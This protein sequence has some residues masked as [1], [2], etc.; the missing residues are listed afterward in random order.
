MPEPLTV[1]TVLSW[2]LTHLRQCVDIMLDTAKAIDSEASGAGA[3]VEQ[4]ES[5]FESAAGTASRQR[6]ADDKF[7]ATAT[8]DV[9]E[10]L[11]NSLALYVGELETNIAT[12]REQK[13]EAEDS[14]WDLFVAD[15]GHVKSRKSNWE[16]YSDY[17]PLGEA[18]IAAKEFWTRRYDNLISAALT[19][20]Q[21]VDQEGAELYIRH[22]EDLS[23]RVKKAVTAAP[24]DPELARILREYQTGSSTEPPRLWPVGLIADLLEESGI[25]V[26]PSL[27]TSEE[28]AAMEQLYKTRGIE[29]VGQALQMPDMA[30][31]AALT[32]SPETEADGHGDAFRHMYWNALM[33]QEFGAD[34]TETYATAHEKTGGNNPQREA[35]DLWNNQLGREIGAANP[36]A[37][38]E[39][40][41][42]LIRHE[43]EG[44]N[45]RALVITANDQAGNS[46]PSDQVNL[47][48]SRSTDPT[49]TGPPA[50][51]GIPLPGSK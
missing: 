16:T 44:E 4:S 40:L 34:W 32:Y 27:F 3:K 50:G 26:S 24:A 1:S 21:R 14:V 2:D 25:E 51:V 48:W 35:M 29:A 18:A 19:W 45:G 15:D 22:I 49:L 38:P 5:Y 6:G 30:K 47:S 12:I 36:N 20:V 13:K 37:T 43:I 17:F 33:A 7:D 46:L 10:A 11:G 28:I 31:E 39:E 42:A 8:S 9:I 41:Q 23:D